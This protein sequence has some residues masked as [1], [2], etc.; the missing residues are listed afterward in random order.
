[1]KTGQELSKDNKIKRLIHNDIFYFSNA[2]YLRY[3]R[4][5]NKT[6]DIFFHLNI[7]SIKT[8]HAKF[9]TFDDKITYN[10]L[11]YL[12]ES[13]YPNVLQKSNIFLKFESKIIYPDQQINLA[14]QELKS[15]MEIENEIYLNENTK[16]IEIDVL[17]KIKGGIFKAILDGIL[18]F[19]D[20]ILFNPILFPIKAVFDFFILVFWKIP[21]YLIKLMIWGVKFISWFL[22]EVCNPN[23]L[24]SDFGTTLKTLIFS[25]VFAIFELFKSFLKKIVNA[26]GPTVI[27]GFWGW[28]QV[29]D[30]TFDEN[31]TAY[32]DPNHPH[33]KRKCYATR[34][35]K[36][37]FS[38]LIGTVIY[39]PLGVFMEYGLTGW[40]QIII[41]GFLTLLFYFPGLIYALI[42]LYC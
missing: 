16:F 14:N 30:S 28:D 9:H 33:N 10:Q 20:E 22:T 40:V 4:H 23:M 2:E 15:N 11:F 21:I 3:L 24:F 38:I 26:F 29:K 41:S 6:L 5:K 18:Y 8:I 25:I 13:Y 39:P 35:N 1:M 17:P 42:C 12:L 7:G 31:Q 34:H 19:F 27:N 36:V 37:P 32:F